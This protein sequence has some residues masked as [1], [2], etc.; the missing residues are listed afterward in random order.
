MINKSTQD[1]YVSQKY[2]ISNLLLYNVMDD[3]FY[4]KDEAFYTPQYNI[5]SQIIE[6]TN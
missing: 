1:V 2:I 5:D 4:R 6:E 3:N